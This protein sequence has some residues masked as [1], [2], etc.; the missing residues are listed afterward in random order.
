MNRSFMETLK[1]RKTEWLCFIVVPLI[2]LA[3]I[4]IRGLPFVRLKPDSKLYLS[5]ADNYLA[6][7]HFVQTARPAGTFV[8]PF[9]LPVILTLFRAMHMSLGAIIAAEYLVVCFSCTLLAKAEKRLFGG[10]GWVSPLVYTGALIRTHLEVNDIYPEYFFLFCLIA[11]IYLLTREDMPLNKRLIWLNA[12]CLAGYLI[13]TVLIV[14][15]LPVLAYTLYAALRRRV[16]VLTALL[17]VLIPCLVLYGIGQVNEKEVGHR[18]YTSNYAGNDIY[19]A[20]NPNTKTD[21]FSYKDHGDFVGDEYYA[22][23]SNADLDPTEKN[24]AFTEA[25]GKWI[26][27]NPEQFMKNTLFKTWSLFVQYWRYTSLIALLCGVWLII[28]GKGF[29]RPMGCLLLLFNALLALITGMGLLVGRY[30]IVIWPISAIHL[31][32]VWHW[33]TGQI[34]KNKL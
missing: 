1:R 13:R 9:G 19:T 30:S 16:S 10:T 17:S 22:I 26:R 29:S 32:G 23:D 27:S 3:Y 6:T 14:V 5:I 18:I 31:A 15:Y 4:R 28:L 7:G 24:T 33:L 11:V 21:F 8:V 2:I 20:N 12:V 25:A 34:K